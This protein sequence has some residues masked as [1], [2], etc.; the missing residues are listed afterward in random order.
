MQNR[1]LSA[2]KTLRNF[3]ILMIIFT[4][5]L[6]GVAIAQHTAPASSTWNV[7]S[8]IKKLRQQGYWVD[9]ADSPLKIKNKFAIIAFQK[10]MGF[11]RD[12]ILTDQV[13]S[14]IMGSTAPAIKDSSH[15]LHIEVD[16]NR[17]ILFVIDSTDSIIHI[18]PVSTGNGKQFLYPDKGLEYARTP[19]GRFKIY[20]K[21]K[22]WK[23]SE[24][25]LLYD[26]LYIEGGFAIHGASEVPSYPASHGCI[27]IPLFAADSLY[28][29]ALIG[30][31]V[32]IFGIN[33]SPN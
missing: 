21:I 14:K 32:V 30:T 9:T 11:K 2:C 25:G 23:E 22:G 29:L 24:L 5:P 6:T 31:P 3:S 15:H 27:R 16:L 28:A 12:G 8:I 19:R 20:Y 7:G 4:T 13:A 1:I 17:Q 10:V 26:P 18:L 33:P